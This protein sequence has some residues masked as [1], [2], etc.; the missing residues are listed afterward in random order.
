MPRPAPPTDTIRVSLNGTVWGHAY[1]NVFWCRVTTAGPRTINDLADVLDGFIA[2]MNTNFFGELNDEVHGLTADGVWQTGVG[3]VLADSRSASHSGS[4]A[5]VLKEAAACYVIDWRIGARYRGGK[6]RTYLP[7]PTEGSIDNGSNVQ[8]SK[9]TALA[10][11]AV[12][13]MADIN[14]LTTTNITAVELGTV[15]F[16]TA[17]GSVAV[18]PVYRVPPVFE[19]YIGSGV[20]SILGTQRRRLTS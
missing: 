11:G 14:A 17:G 8:A 10:A 16:F 3:T 9:Q 4:S 6:P 15:S 13:F 2:A 1:T 18:P 12:G 5:S 19:P 20:R 7:G